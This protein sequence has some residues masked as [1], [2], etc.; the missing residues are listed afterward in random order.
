MKPFT[1]CGCGA[2]GLEALPYGWWRKNAIFR[3]TS[4]AAPPPQSIAVIAVHCILQC[5]QETRL[6]VR[7]DVSALCS[8]KCVVPSNSAL[9]CTEYRMASRIGREET[10]NYISIRKYIFCHLCSSSELHSL[11]RDPSAVYRIAV[12]WINHRALCQC[13]SMQI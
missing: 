6:W 7:P 9:K 11:K 12:L 1:S 3:A 8:V 2:F 5:S 10:S 4:L 13:R